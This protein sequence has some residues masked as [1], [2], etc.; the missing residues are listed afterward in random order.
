MGRPIRFA[1][2]II[3]KITKIAE[4]SLNQLFVFIYH[5]Y[6]LITGI[7]ALTVTLKREA[8]NAKSISGIPGTYVLGPNLISSK[9][10]WL[11][12]SGSNAIWY[13]EDGMLGKWIIGSQDAIGQTYVPSILSYDDV[14]SPQEAT[15]WQYYDGK[16]FIPSKDILVE[17]GT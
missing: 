15:T 4:T 14:D 10:H 5:S 2:D 9:S 12:D 3:K 8:K 6:F 11:Q 1:L 16:M 7:D 13:N 17:P